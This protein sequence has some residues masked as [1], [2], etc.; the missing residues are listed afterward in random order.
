M[1]AGGEN[2]MQL[3]LIDIIKLAFRIFFDRKVR[4][5]LLGYRPEVVCL[6][7]ENNPAS[8]YLVIQPSAR[9]SLWVPPHEGITLKETI[10][11]AVIRCLGIELGLGEANIQFRRS[12][13]LG[14]RVLPE[15]RWDERDIQFSLRG[16]FSKHKMIGKAYFG[17][18][19][20]ADAAATVKPNGA[21]VK[22]WDWVNANEFRKRIKTNS[23]DKIPILE[24]LCQEFI[25]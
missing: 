20:I 17:A 14:K 11:D 24:K 6:V 1:N 12:V 5:Q 13:W 7:R 4:L 3:E 15:S 9:P 2:M 8:R 16:I 10:E 18:F 25:K 22:K 21:E 23:K 19:V